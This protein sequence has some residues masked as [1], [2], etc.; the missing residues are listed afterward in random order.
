[1]KFTLKKPSFDPTLLVQRVPRLK[2]A[3]Y[4]SDNVFSKRVLIGSIIFTFPSEEG[5][6][7]LRG[8]LWTSRLQGKGSTFISQLFQDPEY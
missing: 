8:H 5:T 1:M 2:N 6:A 7:I 3:L 4:L